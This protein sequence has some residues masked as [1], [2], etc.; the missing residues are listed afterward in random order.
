MKVANKQ[1]AADSHETT[2]NVDLNLRAFKNLEDADRTIDFL[3]NDIGR[4]I[5]EEKRKCR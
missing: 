5:G 2:T 4:N 3:N 1:R